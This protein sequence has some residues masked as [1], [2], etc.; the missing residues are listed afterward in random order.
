MNPAQLIAEMVE[1]LTK[2]VETGADPVTAL[3]LTQGLVQPRQVTS[4][5]TAPLMA[6]EGVNQ[7]KLEIF[8]GFL[9]GVVKQKTKHAAGRQQPRLAQLGVKRLNEAVER[10]MLIPVDWRRLDVSD[11]FGRG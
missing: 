11:V 6:G 8:G 10:V 2:R 4:L 1:D 5:P 7:R 3:L 9:A